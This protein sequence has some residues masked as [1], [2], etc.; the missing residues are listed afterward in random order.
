MSFNKYM[1]LCNYYNQDGEY[2]CQPKISLC[3]FTVSP[4]LSHQP[5]KTLIPAAIVWLFN[6]FAFSL[7]PLNVA[8]STEHNLLSRFIHFIDWAI[9][10]LYC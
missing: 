4:F 5:W 10:F 9:L 2:F 8:S 1:Q 6:S 3:P 7:M